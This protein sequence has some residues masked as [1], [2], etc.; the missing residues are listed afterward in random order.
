MENNEELLN[1]TPFI[2]EA[3]IAKERL[4]KEIDKIYNKDKYTYY[5]YAKN[6]PFYNHLLI[7]Q[8]TIVT[9]EYSRKLLGILVHAEDNEYPNDLFYLIKKGYPV[10]FNYVRQKEDEIDIEVLS[11]FFHRKDMGDDE[12]NGGLILAFFLATTM[13]KEI[14]ENK[15][16]F[17]FFA[18]LKLRKEISLIGKI[19]SSKIMAQ[20]PEIKE[21]IEKL[22]RRIENYIEEPIDK[23]WYFQ[24][25]R[26]NK[27]LNVLTN[28]IDTI[29]E[30][31]ELSLSTILNNVKLTK[32]DFFDIGLIYWNNNKNMDR[33]KASEFFIV[34]TV[35]KSLLKAYTEAKDYY[36]ENNEEVLLLENKRLRDELK[37]LKEQSL[38]KKKQVERVEIENER[39]RTSYRATLEEKIKEHEKEIINLRAKLCNEMQKGT[40]LHALR[41]FVFQ[42]TH[43]DLDKIPEEEINIPKVDAII[44]GGHDRWQTRLKEK[45]P[46]TFSF[47]KADQVNFDIKKLYDVEYVFINSTYMSHGLYYKVVENL[48]S[49]V[50]LNFL[51]GG[52]QQSLRKIDKVI[53]RKI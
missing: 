49:L 8:G 10:I 32:R 35:V 34:G 44:F 21:K 4:R 43:G 6:S 22:I 31:E 14:K 12:F 26:N 20:E 45:L 33:E 25:I 1:I 38:F 11:K 28:S 47:V 40:E 5:T 19:D 53:N 2:V 50:K 36:F 18:F 16:L 46:K 17:D 9:Q 30:I 3:L 13:G 51:V 7:T 39:L 48:P 42:L 24:N 23:P 37:Q 15:Y 27:E 41:N 29:V 52:T